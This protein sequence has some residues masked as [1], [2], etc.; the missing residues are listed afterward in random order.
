MDKNEIIAAEY[1]QLLK[2]KE[3]HN[4]K[5]W[6]PFENTLQGISKAISREYNGNLGDKVDRWVSISNARYF[7]R[8][9]PVSYYFQ[10]KMLYRDG[11]YEAAIVLSRSICEMICYDF[12]SRISHP[13][14]SYENL[15]MENFRNL[16][17]FLGIP[18]SFS[19]EEFQ[20]DIVAKLSSNEEANFIKSSYS[21]DNSTNRYSFKIKNGKEPKNLKRLHNIFDA[22]SYTQK[23]IFPADTFTLI[24]QV[25]D[26]GNTYVHARKSPNIPKEDAFSVINRIGLVLAHLYIVNGGLSGKH[27]ISGYA[28]FPDICQ[29]TNFGLDVY[30]TP[31][32]A[33]RG[34]YN[35][36]SQHQLDKMFTME[37]KWVEEPKS[38]GQTHQVVV[39]RFFIEGEY[40]KAALQLEKSPDDIKDM[41]IKCFGD[42]FH[43][44]AVVKKKGQK[45]RFKFELELL[46]ENTLIGENLITGGRTVFN[47]VRDL[48]QGGF[49]RTKN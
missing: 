16:A 6:L 12:L 23:G 29:G 37:G 42:Y 32:D 11:F 14:G 5:K 30:A 24:N 47:R 44:V 36:P 1:E 27:V 31:V 19:K 33:Y 21:L 13:F 15:E 43:I 49:A 40:L 35:M 8:S 34:Y 45:P 2:V 48:E 7:R 28:N 39:L 17:R 20:K 46:N 3:F 41:A 26:D 18:K 25:Y 9:L 22:I 10:A 38:Y 4:E